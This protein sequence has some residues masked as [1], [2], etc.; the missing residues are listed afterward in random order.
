MNVIFH[1]SYTN[2]TKKIKERALKEKIKRAVRS[3]EKAESPKDIP[4]FMKLEGEEKH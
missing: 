4:N 2:A 1:S 3:V